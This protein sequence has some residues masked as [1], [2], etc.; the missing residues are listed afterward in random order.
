ML[1]LLLFGI[2]INDLS[3]ALSFARVMIYADGTQ[4]YFHFFPKKIQQAIARASID[5]QAVANWATEN[6]LLLNPSKTK[7]MILGSELC[8]TRVDLT[9]LPRVT[10]DGH[11]LP[12][13]SEARSLGVI[14]TPTLDWKQHA[15]EITRR[16]YCTLYTLRFHRRSLSRELR[17]SL[18]ECLVFPRFD[19]ACIVYHHLDDTRIGK[20]DVALRACVR[21]VVGC[22]PFLAHVIPHLLGLHWLSALRRR[23]YFIGTL[24]YSVVANGTSAYLMECFR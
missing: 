5:A 17:K 6:R 16:V 14:I 8:T 2:Y 15:S 3:V 9:T 4:V 18:V 22:L 1:G 20:I 11:A 24:A 21:F 23:E 7:V 19:Y 12:Y 13:V 10:I